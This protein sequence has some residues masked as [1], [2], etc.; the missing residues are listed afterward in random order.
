MTDTPI[1]YISAYNEN[2]IF[3]G[4]KSAR[5]LMMKG[6]QRKAAT[7]TTRQRVLEDSEDS[8]GETEV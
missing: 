1:S 2:L 3:G 5:D 6:K 7:S 8:D 4:E